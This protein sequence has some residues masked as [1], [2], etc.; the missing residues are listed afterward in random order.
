[1]IIP[2]LQRLIKI[3]PQFVAVIFEYFCKIKML[4]LG[5]TFWDDWF[6]YYYGYS[7]LDTVIL[8]TGILSILA[9]HLKTLCSY[10]L[11][12]MCCFCSFVCSVRRQFEKSVQ[13]LKIC[14]GFI[15]HYSN[16]FSSKW[17]F[18]INLFLSIAGGFVHLALIRKA[19]NFIHKIKNRQNFHPEKAL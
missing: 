4:D 2:I 8:C 9:G 18:R 19:L 6:V 14:F 5:W 7:G 11:S 13:Y 12:I 16:F 10:S 17:E 15:G 3:L 1:M